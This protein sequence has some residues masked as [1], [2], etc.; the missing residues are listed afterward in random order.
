M[1]G[2]IWG[3]SIISM[4]IFA[5]R[6]GLRGWH[7]ICLLIYTVWSW[8]PSGAHCRGVAKLDFV[9]EIYVAAIHSREVRVGAYS[10]TVYNPAR[11]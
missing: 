8:V 7:R 5:C 6:D 3:F 1:Q 10:S 4:V 2:C 11:A 9:V